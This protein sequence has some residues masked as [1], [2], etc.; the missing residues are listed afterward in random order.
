MGRCTFIG[1]SILGK[2][3]LSETSSDTHDIGITGNNDNTR[4]I[5]VLDNNDDLNSNN[6]SNANNKNLNNINNTNN[7]NDPNNGNTDSSAN[8]DLNCIFTDLDNNDSLDELGDDVI[9]SEY[10]LHNV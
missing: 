4:S 7:T 8:I 2:R 3:H 5:M 10:S 9:N 1:T 6:T